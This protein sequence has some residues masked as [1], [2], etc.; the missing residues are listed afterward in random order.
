MSYQGVGDMSNQDEAQQQTNGFLEIISLSWLG[1]TSLSSPKIWKRWLDRVR[2]RIHRDGELNLNRV[3][4][5][6]WTD[7]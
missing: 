7:V 2:P 6:G 4:N 3:E 1:N 5:N